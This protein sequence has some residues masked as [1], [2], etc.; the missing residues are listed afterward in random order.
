MTTLDWVL[1]LA[2]YRRDA[3]YTTALLHEHGIPSKES[4][5]DNLADRLAEAPG[6]LI[7]THEALSPC[8]INTIASFLNEQPAWSEIPIV[9]LLDRSVPH[10][11]IHKALSDAWPHSRQMFYQRPVVAL[12]L[13]SGIQSALSTR[14]RQRE[15]RDH[16]DRETELR[17]ELNHR[18]K[19]ILASV[20]SLFEMTRRQAH[21]LEGFAEDF[22]GRLTALSDIHSAVFQA[23][24]NEVPLEDIVSLVLAPYRSASASVKIAGPHVTVPHLAATTIALCL[25][26][27]A[28]NSVKYGA[29]SG[30]AGIIDL[31]WTLSSEVD[32]M[33]TFSWVEAGGPRV[34]EP[35][36]VGYGTR[37]LRS[38]LRS[39]F[40]H[41]P[42]L[43]F[44]PEGLRCFVQG[45]LSRVKQ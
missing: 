3:T 36:R 17:L 38:G 31:K 14:L 11:Q 30:A 2:P 16:L 24:H 5:A 10:A 42:Q 9:V 32:Q 13:I 8:V 45:P 26:E 23:G 20:I 37:Y 43:E 40:G 34:A 29:L 41:L 7:V 39:V 1:V 12:E 28:T 35:S 44:A 18:V 25:H 33:L 19:N 22:R 21:T 4:S 27:L 15:V 6:I